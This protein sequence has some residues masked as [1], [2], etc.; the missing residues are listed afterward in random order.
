[1]LGCSLKDSLL[2]D[3]I[4]CSNMLEEI[5]AIQEQ[6][7]SMMD[8]MQANSMAL[9]RGEMD[10]AEHLVHFNEWQSQESKLHKQVDVLFDSAEGSDCL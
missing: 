2:Q 6:R 1:M 8:E 9:R 5:L 3:S 7:N 10:K 4:R